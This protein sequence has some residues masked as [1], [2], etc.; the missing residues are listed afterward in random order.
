[1]IKYWIKILKQ[2]DSS[3]VKKTYLLLESDVVANNTNNKNNWAYHIKSMLEQ[4]GLHYIWTQQHEI[5]IPFNIIKQRIFDMYYQ[6]W[7][8]EIN[9]S[10]RLMSYSIF[11]HQFEIEKYLNI[12]T[13]NKFRIALSRFRTSSHDLLIERGRYENIP[14]DQRICKSCNMNQIE[15][16]YHF[17][18]VCPKYRYL[19]LKYFKSYYCHWP[20]LH[21]YETLLSA[22]SAKII[23]NLAKFI[24]FAM[25]VRTS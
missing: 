4:H 20:N 1:M 16:E 2:N 17:L 6:K 5:D 11:K 12:T 14:R 23:C 13:D 18:L 24:Y 10:S 8:R 15:N 9:N 21:K 22:T 7:Y 3:L 25:K 19:Q